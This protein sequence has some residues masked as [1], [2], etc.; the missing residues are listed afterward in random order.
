MAGA[1]EEDAH[2]VWDIHIYIHI[3]IRLLDRAK[4]N[5]N[6]EVSCRRKR[7]GEMRRGNEFDPGLTMN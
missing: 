2:A 6:G 4:E 1:T 5:Q 7:I 3:H